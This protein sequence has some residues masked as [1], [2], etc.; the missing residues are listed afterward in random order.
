M[1]VSS[2]PIAPADAVQLHEQVE[3]IRASGLLGRSGLLPRLF[4]FLYECSRSG[5]A[6]KEIEV[7]IDGFGRDASFDVSQ[8]A[9]VR[10]YV[11]KLRRKLEE[12]YGA[13]GKGESL[14]IIIPK[15]EYKLVLEAVPRAAAVP[16]TEPAPIMEP[17]VA[18]RGDA[19]RKWLV[20]ALAA[21]LLLNVLLPVALHKSR[22]ASSEELK[23]VRAAA[24]WSG[25]LAG[26]RPIYV[27]VG[28]YYI[29]GETDGAMDAKRLVRD[30]TIN[31]RDDLDRYLQS[32]PRLADSYMDVDLSYLPVSTAFALRYVLP[33]LG[34]ANNRIHVVAMSDLNPS[35]IK[36]ADL[37]YIG[38]LSGLGMLSDTVFA[39]SRFST[40]DTFDEVVDNKTKKHY[41]S[42]EGSPLEGHNQF[43]DY[44]YLSSFPGPNG[45][46]IV[47]ISG[48][49]DVGVMHA[50]AALTDLKALH[51]LEQ[52]ASGAP[53]REA[54]Y[55]V[56]GMN[57]TDLKGRLVTA[58]PLAAG[59]V[60]ND[61]VPAAILPPAPASQ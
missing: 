6:P 43:R 16:E 40:G 1:S 32:H 30:F 52:A 20:A 5:R 33:V 8:D 4:D 41:I 45:N 24:P 7:A 57:R 21:S 10:V 49:R 46:H 29:F 11:H 47:V 39:G 17:I 42:E 37:I 36:S 50:A 53:A 12:F 14:R 27:V 26:D 55:E 59:S 23:Q 15:G 13:A 28:D 3:K 56:D 9:S 18:P 25:I 31:S 61:R 48:T 2:L 19:W 51:E 35:V 44:C 58:S 34:A 60:W 38:Y 54:L 22:S